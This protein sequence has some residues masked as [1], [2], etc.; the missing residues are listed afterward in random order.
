VITV[1]LPDA[2]AE[3]LMGGLPAGY[4]ADVWAADQDPPPSADQVEVV[5]PP[6]EI[7]RPR[8]SVLAGLPRLRL[9]QLESAGADWIIPYLPPGVTLCTA[10]GAYD[11]A[12]AEWVTGAVLAHLRLLPR[13]VLAQRDGRWDAAP[14]DTLEGKTMLIVGY[15]SIGAELSRMLSGFDVT[16]EKVARRARPGVHDT[17]SLTA[18]LPQA[19]IVVLLL[20]GTPETT[21]LVDAAFLAR[22]RDGA[23][24]VNAARGAVVDTD[25][26]LGEL[27]TGRLYAALDVTATEPLPPGHP[28]WSAPGLLL[29]P[30]V[31][32]ATG[33]PMAR[34]MALAKAQLVRYAAGQPLANVVTE[35]GY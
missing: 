34:A 4:R 18:L 14:A 29:T 2:A 19:D 16:I 3:N 12:V 20:P 5:I 22:M 10:R 28:L 8:L 35:A 1:W 21:G 6:F 11:G 9:V 7:A 30:H 26:L 33:R 31:A 15:G 32:G 27:C 17:G 25:A 23:L 24:L 13:F